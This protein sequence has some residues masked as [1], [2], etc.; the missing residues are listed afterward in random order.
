MNIIN[1]KLCVYI[2]G[3]I[4]VP[5]LYIYYF[6]L[7]TLLEKHDVEYSRLNL[8]WS[9]SACHEDKYGRNCEGT[10]N[11]KNGVCNSTDG[12]CSCLPGYSGKHC[13]E[14]KTNS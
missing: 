3:G 12:S 10:C 8:H 9:F 2:S 1:L 13:N 5:S 4:F 6:V 7:G 14:S 11:C